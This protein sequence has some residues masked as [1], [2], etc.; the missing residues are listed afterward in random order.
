M[1]V[2]GGKVAPSDGDTHGGKAHEGCSKDAGH[3]KARADG[4]CGLV[5]QT[6]VCRFQSQSAHRHTAA[7]VAPS[8]NAT[9]RL[10][11]LNASASRW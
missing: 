2:G 7:E 6:V 9:K 1:K 3:A 10:L 11:S 5:Q 4:I 8:S